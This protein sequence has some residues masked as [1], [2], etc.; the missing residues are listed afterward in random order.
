L[1]FT[2]VAE[3]P[4]AII[5]ACLLFP[6]Q[7][8]NGWFED[9]VFSAFP[10]FKD[11]V[12]KMGNDM[13]QNRGKTP[14]DTPYVFALIVDVILGLGF[15][16]VLNYFT[17]NMYYAAMGSTQTDRVL[18]V[19]NFFGLKIE[20]RDTLSR[21]SN[22]LT[23]G[24]PLI[25][26]FFFGTRPLRFAMGI[27]ALFLLNLMMQ[28]DSRRNL[29][30]GGAKRT[31]FGVLRVNWDDQAVIRRL[32][33][34]GIVKGDTSIERGGSLKNLP[35]EQR[36]GK[37]TYLMHGT[38]HHGLNF[39]YPSQLSRLATTYYHRLGP[40]GAIME[41]YNWF[42]GPQNT[43]W[44]DARMPASLVG[45][46]ASPLGAGTVPLDALA[47]AGASEPPYATIGLGT[48]T[49][50]SY[51]RWLQHVTFY[52][53]D[54]VIRSFSEPFDVKPGDPVERMTDF[55]DKV[56]KPFFTFLRDASLRGANV[57]VIMG[58]AYQSMKR[59]DPK[60]TNLFHMRDNYY[61]AIEVDAFSSDAIPIHLVT[62]EA[63]ALYMS[64]L[65]PDGVVLMHTS[66]RHM[67]LVEP[68]VDIAVDLGLDWRVCKD[69]A[70]KGSYL[71]LFSS[72][73]VVLAHKGSTI[74]KD[75]KEVN[76]GL[77]LPD[78]P[79]R[80]IQLRGGGVFWEGLPGGL[81]AKEG[82]AVKYYKQRRTTPERRVWTLDFSNIWSIL[83]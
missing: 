15:I 18:G 74:L 41:R 65:A 37:Y 28:G 35:L 57:E 9:L 10:G 82:S 68:I 64:K 7:R 77:D 50:A 22:L 63:I 13:A 12:V 73:Y 52:E 53:I 80:A 60:G 81:T 4:I 29:V 30:E 42:P 1:F 34:G 79:P 16:L 14:P 72:E 19:A 71:G 36:D 69:E 49:M 46:A 67:N 25:F 6:K 55:S 59:E 8:E 3:Y 21:W 38:T 75:K 78:N 32:E 45:L 48:G 24:P 62:K 61:K 33:S 26:C 83:R 17:R 51:G 47:H 2:G 66:N 70:E 43:F 58:D 31:Y 54:S 27:T 56:Q 23:F 20:D 76:R 5:V 39:H 11:S 40:V 44:A